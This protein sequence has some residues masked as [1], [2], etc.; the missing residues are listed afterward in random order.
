MYTNSFF[1]HMTPDQLTALRKNISVDPDW[2]I[3]A[4]GLDAAFLYIF[5]RK[6]DSDA[7]SALNFATIVACHYRQN[8]KAADWV[9]SLV[10]IYLP[11]VIW[12]DRHGYVFNGVSSLT[13]YVMP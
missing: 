10:Q 3:K 1:H 4:K 5:S 13:H 7:V 2:A 9:I 11:Y 8:R 6:F 12:A